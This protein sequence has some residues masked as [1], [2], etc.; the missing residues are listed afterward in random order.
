M[1]ILTRASAG[2][3]PWAISI[4]RLR[5]KIAPSRPEERWLD[6]LPT[7]IVASVALVLAQ[8]LLIG[9]VWVAYRGLVLLFS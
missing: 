2:W 9:T 3:N 8:A 7:I 4:S 5:A 6:L 1:L